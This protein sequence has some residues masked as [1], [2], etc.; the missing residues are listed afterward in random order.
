ML[1]TYSKLFLLAIA[2]GVCGCSALPPRNFPEKKVKKMNFISIVRFVPNDVP[3]MIAEAKRKAEASGI[4]KNAY[5]MSILPRGSNPL[6]QPER[7]AKAFYEYG[8]ETE[9]LLKNK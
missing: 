5:C 7:Y 9:K 8:L 1:K 6:A 3:G 4:Y 2:A